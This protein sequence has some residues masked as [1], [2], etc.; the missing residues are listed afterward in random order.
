MLK[1]F[2]IYILVQFFISKTN[3]RRLDFLL[4]IPT[5]L[6]QKKVPINVTS[7]TNIG[8]YSRMSLRMQIQ[9]PL[10]YVSLAGNEH[11]TTHTVL[12]SLNVGHLCRGEW[13]TCTTGG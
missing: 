8:Y 1:Y 6:P 9:T 13:G 10:S 11:N 2:Y 7:S 3:W 12:I 4:I 5:S